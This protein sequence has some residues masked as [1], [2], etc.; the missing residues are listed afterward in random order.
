[1]VAIGLKFG[2]K[3]LI[4]WI[5]DMI[6]DIMSVKMIINMPG[7]IIFDRKSRIKARQAFGHIAIFR[8]KN[9]DIFL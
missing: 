1:M 8:S 3:L 5:G 7:C 9:W 6:V 2:G 4:D